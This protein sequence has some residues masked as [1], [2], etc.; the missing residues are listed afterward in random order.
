MV[1][2][3]LLG[4]FIFV[5]GVGLT[6]KSTLIKNT[7]LKYLYFW[8]GIL[9]INAGLFLTVNAAVIE[10][11]HMHDKVNADPRKGEVWISSHVNK[12]CD[13]TTLVYQ[14]LTNVSTVPNS[15]ECKA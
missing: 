3:I 7:K 14:A 15:P 12:V 2:L 8:P 5:T 4:A 6:L 1:L 9:F 11:H 13:G 10:S